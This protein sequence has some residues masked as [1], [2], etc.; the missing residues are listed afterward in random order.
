MRIA[1]T[2]EGWG[3]G[4]GGEREREGRGEGERALAP[5]PTAWV[6]RLFSSLTSSSP[7]P[8]QPLSLFSDKEAHRKPPNIFLA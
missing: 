2:R 3:W 5:S 8:F 4:W 6:L 1:G 7:M